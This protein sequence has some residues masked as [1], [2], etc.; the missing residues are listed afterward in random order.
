MWGGE[1]GGGGTHFLLGGWVD[2][3]GG[4]GRLRIE[5]LGF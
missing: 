5:S 1:G 3:R 2:V 4:G